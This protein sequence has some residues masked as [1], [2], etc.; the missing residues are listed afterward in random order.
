MPQTLPKTPEVDRDLALDHGLTDD[1]YDEIRDRLGRTPSFVE[2]GIYSVMWSEHCSYKNS[3]ALLKTLPQ[4]GERLLAEVGE[5]NAGLVDVGDGQAVAFKIES[6]NHPSAVEPYEGAA[7]GVGGIHRDIFTMGARPICALDSLRF[8]SLEKSRVRYLFDGVVRGIGD[9]GNS[10]GVPTVA[11]EV[12]FEDAYEGNPLVNAMSVGVVD[13]D[14]TARAA[15]DTPGHSV[16]VVGA[17]TG[18]DGIHG[19]TFASAEIDEDSEEDRPS[20]Q[21]GD[22]FTEKLLLE[23]TLEA[24]RDGV[25][26]GIQDM[27]AAGLTSSSFEM[28]ASSDT[29]MDLHLDRVPTR[30]EGMTPYEIMLSESQERMLVVC[31]PGDE[32]ALAEIYGKWD[33]NAQRIG[34]V[35]D[36]GRVRAYW[37]GDEVATLDPAHVAGDDVPVYDRDTERPAYLEKTRSFETEDVPDVQPSEAEETLT[38][39]LGSPNIASKRWVHEQYD[40]MVRTNTVVGPGASDAAVVRLKGTGKGLAVKTDCN[41]RYVYLNPRRGAQIAVAEAAR[42]VTCAGGTPVAITNCCNFGNPHNPEVYWT[43]AEAIGGMGDACRALGT[44]VTGGNVSLYNEHPE[45]AIYPTPTIGML[46]LVDDIETHPTTAALQNEGD[47]LFLLTPSG[48]THPEGIGGTEYLSTV[49]DRITGDVPHLDL[50]EEVAVQSAT[51]ALIHEGLV[52]HAHD[53]SDGGLA[54]CLAESVIHSDGLGLEATLPDADRLDTALFGEAQSRVV[55]SVQ[56]DDVA[57]FENA[58]SGHDAVQSHRLGT[59]TTGRLRVTINGES[60]LDASRDALATP[61]ETAIPEAVA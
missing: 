3:I 33:L 2:L 26:A 31:E 34:T 21:V 60:I 50:D 57:S 39:L 37:H 61:Y 42:N 43:F 35:T 25:V 14:R 23:A 6:H 7:T 22:P 40:T 9:Y 18:R 56:P 4:E 20:V 29:G 55:L 5:E 49:H 13:T 59:V 16:L 54:V 48:W 24:I 51:Q 15:A 27:G 8:G 52:Q 44:P 41:G 53:V 19:A 10:F 47:V 17:D 58:L 32:E 12:Y 36:T 1:E 38:T 28:C 45:G 30:E 11:G 46:G